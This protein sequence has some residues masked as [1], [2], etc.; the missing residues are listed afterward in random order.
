M[1]MLTQKA[2]SATY[3]RVPEKLADG[4]YRSDGSQA[5]VDFL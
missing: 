5:V 4:A 3:V 2:M 1:W